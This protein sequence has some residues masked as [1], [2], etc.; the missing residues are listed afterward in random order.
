M[1]PWKTS[2]EL[3]LEHPYKTESHTFSKGAIAAYYN[4]LEY[5]SHVEEKFAVVIRKNGKV[6][7]LFE[8][9]DYV[10]DFLGPKD[11]VY[12][13]EKTDLIKVKTKEVVYELDK[14]FDK[15]EKNIRR[16]ITL[17]GRKEIVLRESTASETENLY[18][19][20][21]QHKMDDPKTFRISFT[22]K[23]YLRCFQ[24][25]EKGFNIVEFAYYVNGELY[26]RLA[27]EVQGEIAFELAYISRF[28]RKDLK[29][30]NDLNECVL[31]NSFHTLYTQGV[32]KINVGPTAGI[33]GLKI[34]KSKLPY[35]E[36]IVYSN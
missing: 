18:Q 36:T 1:N 21:A 14:I 23:R 16:G 7:F 17:L 19:E 33:R 20:W 4:L 11:T 10:A 22:P 27:Y 35:I 8:K 3:L 12:S 5:P 2:L 15:P 30:I 24:L 25:K 28:W 29:L 34:F 13:S 31:I 9:L 32:K 6:F 26:A